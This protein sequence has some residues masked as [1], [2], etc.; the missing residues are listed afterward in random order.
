MVASSKPNCDSF[1]DGHLVGLFR[2]YC[3][4]AI[5][6]LFEKS[7]TIVESDKDS[8]FLNMEI[9]GTKLY[10]IVSD[11]SSQK[12]LVY[13]LK[14]SINGP[15]KAKVL[16]EC[17]SISPSISEW[18]LSF[19]SKDEALRELYLIYVFYYAVPLNGNRHAAPGLKFLSECGE[20]AQVTKIQMF[21]LDTNKD[22]IEWQN[23]Q[24]EDR[25]AFVSNLCNIVMS[26]DELNCNKDLT[27]GNTIYFALHCRCT[28]PWQGLRLGMFCLTDSSIKYFP[29]EKS[30]HD[31]DIAYRNPPVW[32][33][34]NLL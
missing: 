24:L 22:P 32:F 33:V 25:V 4:I 13:C 8:T 20:P 27:R 16:A 11:D 31:D 9:I 2:D 5:Y 21:K 29:V 17:P 19:L 23:V 28:N 15:P 18:R 34:P 1:S 3:H 30:K 12:V 6:K 14:D 26:R 7:W 10:V